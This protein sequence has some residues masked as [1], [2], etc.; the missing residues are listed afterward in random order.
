MKRLRTLL[1]GLW[2][3]AVSLALLVAL[4]LV[5]LT[6]TVLAPAALLKVAEAPLPAILTAAWPAAGVAGVA[7][8]FLSRR[9]K[10]LSVREIRAYEVLLAAGIAAALAAVFVLVM[11]FPT[12][13]AAIC[14][15]AFA[16]LIAEAVGRIAA[17]ER[18]A[19]RVLGRR[20]ELAAALLG[21]A[22]I[23]ALGALVG[24]LAL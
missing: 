13:F 20:Q 17:L 6:G 1:R 12:G 15:A 9:R 21:L 18:R 2:T 8:L 14:I 24:H 22:S 10:T 19:A 7:G 23:A 4:P 5:A 16:V 11:A 3:V